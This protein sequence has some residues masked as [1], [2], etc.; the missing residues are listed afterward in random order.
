MPLPPEGRDRHG[1]DGPLYALSMFSSGVGEQWEIFPWCMGLHFSPSGEAKSVS[2][3]NHEARNTTFYRF[4]MSAQE[5][6]RRK[7][8]PFRRARRQVTAYLPA[9]S[10]Y[11][12]PFPGKKYCP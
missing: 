1:G 12:P 4:A 10:R 2:V 11:F 8:S 3:A 9:I 7:P 5:W 6:R